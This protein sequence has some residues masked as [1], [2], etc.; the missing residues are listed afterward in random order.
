MSLIAGSRCPRVALLVLMTM[1]ARAPSSS[2]AEPYSV[3]AFV[4][5]G[6]CQVSVNGFPITDIPNPGDPEI[7]GTHSMTLTQYL[8]NGDNAISLTFNPADEI[9]P[10]KSW[11]EFNILHGEDKVLEYRNPD[12]DVPL[13]ADG[14]NAYGATMISG[15]TPE[16]ENA[17]YF[18]L[19]IG[20]PQ[21]PKWK[22]S[23]RLDGKPLQFIPK[24]ITFLDD[25]KEIKQLDVKI[26]AV[27]ANHSAVL[28]G[29]PVVLNEDNKAMAVDLSGLIFPWWPENLVGKITFSIPVHEDYLADISTEAPLSLKSAVIVPRPKPVNAILAF[30]TTGTPSWAWEGADTLPGNL[31]PNDQAAIYAQASA[32]NGALKQKNLI[33]LQ[34]LYAT[35]LFEL[36]KMMGVPAN[37]FQEQMNDFYSE[38]LFADPLW[39]MENILPLADFKFQVLPNMKV[40]EFIRNDGTNPLISVPLDGSLPGDENRFAIPLRFIRQNGNWVIIE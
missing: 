14:L 10:S 11:V 36:G 33:A 29:L 39:D 22:W 37:V 3:S 21:S 13:L 23:V 2:A 18:E 40:V 31:L 35:K 28:N 6:S 20:D 15:S 7:V 8:K 24:N 16:G 19:D 27:N 34:T 5:E 4:H 1:I 30:P 17:I 26:D 12:N 38:L 25:N 9:N 32:L